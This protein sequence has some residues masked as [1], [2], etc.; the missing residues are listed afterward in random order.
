LRGHALRLFGGLTDDRTAKRLVEDLFGG[1]SGHGTVGRVGLRFQRSRLALPPFQAGSS[2]EQPAYEVEGELSLILAR[3]L[4]DPTQEETLKKL[5]AKL[6]Q[7]AMVLG[8]FGKSW[9]RADHR[10][11][12]E[13][14]Y[15]D[16]RCK[17]L[18]GCHWEWVGNR[19]LM[20]DVQV[21]SLEKLGEFLDKV[22]ETA[23]AWMRL[24]Q[25][26]P[27]PD[28]GADWRESWHPDRVQVWGRVAKS[29]ED[30]EAIRWLH[31]PYQAKIP[32]VRSEGSIY[33]S[34]LTGQVGQVG[35]LW[36]RMYPLVKLR[37]KKNDPQGKLE[38]QVTR[39]YLE[40]L[41]IFPDDSPECDQFLAFLQQ[42]P[43][44]FQQLWGN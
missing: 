30:S 32:G 29:Q 22:R 21:R 25:E 16:D 3:P 12:F 24:Q 6:M 34:S 33:R 37:K 28:R 1:V 42:N 18:I 39:E 43:F 9:R 10:L 40:W 35:R 11:F 14:Y 38:P 36:H 2:Y 44:G 31:Q 15:E 26:E 7:F 41:T 5:L 8:G 23:I 4:T 13:D 19:A 20:T 27:Q 17:P